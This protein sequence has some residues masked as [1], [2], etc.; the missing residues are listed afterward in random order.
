MKKKVALGTLLIA[1]LVSAA[2]AIR[3][4]RVI[5]D[6]GVSLSLQG[7]TITTLGLLLPLLPL[8]KR[9]PV[10]AVL[11]IAVV[12]LVLRLLAL[13]ILSS[14]TSWVVR[15]DNF[16]MLGGLL[17]TTYIAASD[18]GG[19]PLAVLLLLIGIPILTALP[20]VSNDLATYASV[21]ETS[22]D[23]SQKAYAVQQSD[24]TQDAEYVQD[25]KTGTLAGVTTYGDTGVPFVFFAGT[26]SW[27]DWV[28]TNADNALERVPSSWTSDGVRGKVHGGFLAS[29]LSVREK[30]WNLLQDY[31]LRNG[32]SRNI[33]VCGHSLG[34]AL[35]TI[36]AADIA[37]RLDPQ[38]AKKLICCTFGAPQVGDAEF[39]ASFNAVVPISLRIVA[40]YDPIPKAYSANLPHVKGLVPIASPPILPYTHSIDAYR[41]G[42]RQKPLATALVMAAPVFS[43]CL[44]AILFSYVAPSLK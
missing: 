44:F 25:Q 27:T 11:G 3:N 13:P 32:G 15:W 36:A 17:A 5:P 22:L 24:Q 19:S 14:T 4:P 34:G 31:M 10:T 37:A 6:H 23:I 16:A 20:R 42:T 33:V 7:A 21:I 18:I 9:P 39:V 12:S 29:Y 43:L 1:Y 30:L 8:Q 26:Q 40:M 2:A 28:R 35:A 41:L 38:D